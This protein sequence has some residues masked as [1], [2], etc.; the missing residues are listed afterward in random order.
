MSVGLN[1][2]FPFPSIIDEERQ[3]LLRVFESSDMPFTV[4]R[5][6]TVTNAEVNA[7][8]GQH[9]HRICNQLICCLAGKV[10]LRCDDGEEVSEIDM[11]P[12]TGGVLVPAGVWAEQQYMDRGSVILVFCDRPYDEG[13][14][15][16]DYEKYLEYL[17]G[18]R[19]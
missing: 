3:G 18:V 5:V 6:F 16:R 14:Y 15:I 9:A 10:L 7:K 2:V 19:A 17:K 8:R 11:T 1:K 4:K 13:D 12:M